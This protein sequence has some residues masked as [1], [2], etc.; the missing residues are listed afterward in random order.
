MTASGSE[1]EPVLIFET[2]EMSL[3]G[4][5]LIVVFHAVRVKTWEK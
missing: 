2:F 1:Y 5:F 3:S 4:A